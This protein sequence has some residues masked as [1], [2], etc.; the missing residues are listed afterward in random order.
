MRK[1]L[2]EICLHRQSA[3]LKSKALLALLPVEQVVKNNLEGM[4]HEPTTN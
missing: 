4:R 1:K 3:S 2:K